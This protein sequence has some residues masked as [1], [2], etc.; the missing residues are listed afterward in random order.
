MSTPK[1]GVTPHPFVR[2]L[3]LPPDH[4]GRGAC[5]TC[6]LI[7][8]PDDAHHTMPDGGDDAQRRAAGE[9]SDG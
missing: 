8:R 1:T 4:N 2:D 5:A 7:G 6:H 3:D 9:R